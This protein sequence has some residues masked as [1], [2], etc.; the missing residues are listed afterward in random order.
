MKYKKF[1]NCVNTAQNTLKQRFSAIQN[2]SVSPKA[3]SLSLRFFAPD[4]RRHP[5]ATNGQIA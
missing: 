5:N 3:A 2:E 4:S 1:N